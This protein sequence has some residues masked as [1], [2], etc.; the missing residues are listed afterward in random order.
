MWCAGRQGT[1][2]V[3]EQKIAALQATTSSTCAQT[4]QSFPGVRSPS[5]STLKRALS[6]LSE[7]WSTASLGPNGFPSSCPT[8]CPVRNASS[9]FGSLARPNRWIRFFLRRRRAAG[10]IC[11]SAQK[12]RLP[13]TKRRKLQ[14]C[15]ESQVFYS[16]SIADFLW[17]IKCEGR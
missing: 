16:P 15:C 7:P 1:R 3:R 2:D 14:S 12:V 13:Q 17:V 6:V 9:C 5:P 4:N 11:T 10:V 8:G